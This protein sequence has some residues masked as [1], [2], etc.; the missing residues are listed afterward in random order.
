[1]RTCIVCACTDDLACVDPLHD[2]ACSWVKLIGKTKGVCSACPVPLSSNR[3]T[4]E[5]RARRRDLV[6]KVQRINGHRRMQFN[7]ARSAQ[8]GY[9]MAVQQLR[10]FERAVGAP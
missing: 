9:E 2:G 3:L 1:M 10:D 4:K 7:H 6:E 8:E 5:Q